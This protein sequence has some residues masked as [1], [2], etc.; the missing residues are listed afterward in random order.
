M[1]GEMSRAALFGIVLLAAAITST[2]CGSLLA[3]DAGKPSADELEQ[4]LS[5]NEAGATAISCAE[6]QGGW[7]YVCTFTARDGQRKKVG[8]LLNEDGLE[9]ASAAVDVDGQLAPPRG[10]GDEAFDSWIAQVNTVCHQNLIAMQAVPPPTSPAEFGD[11]ARQLSQ[12][13]DKYLQALSALPPPPDRE[14]RRVFTQLIALLQQDNQGGLALSRAAQRGDAA[15]VQRLMQK[16]GQ[17][18]AQES[19]LFNRLGGNC[20]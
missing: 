14:D 2:G 20:A 10:E 8:L 9:R 11:Y 4:A 19:E 5:R 18:D 6:A 17:Q 3:S 7:D 13:G 1:L 15:A 12:I 16:L